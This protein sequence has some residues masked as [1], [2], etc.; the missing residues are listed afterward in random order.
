Q[1]VLEIHFT[2]L[3]HFLYFRIGINYLGRRKKMDFKIE[4]L[5]RSEIDRLE[6]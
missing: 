3:L 1:S 4:R 2:T 5:T 6:V